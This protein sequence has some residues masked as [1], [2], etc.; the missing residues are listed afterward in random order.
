[1][2]EWKKEW[3]PQFPLVHN[4]QISEFLQVRDLNVG[5]AV[6]TPSASTAMP[7]RKCS[8]DVNLSLLLSET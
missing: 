7:Q 5:I 4:F 2:K 1:M 8:L 3:H 6:Y